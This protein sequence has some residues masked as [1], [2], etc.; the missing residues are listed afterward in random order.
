M[1]FNYVEQH[2]FANKRSELNE[3]SKS[4]ITSL[5]LNGGYFAINEGIFKNVHSLLFTFANGKVLEVQFNKHSFDITTEEQLSDGNGFY[6]KLLAEHK[7]LSESEH[8]TVLELDKP[9]QLHEVYLY[10]DDVFSDDDS[11]LAICPKALCLLGDDFECVVLRDDGSALF[12]LAFNTGDSRLF[13][14]YLPDGDAVTLFESS[15][16][17]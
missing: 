11:Y 10:S 3:L 9:L 6:I 4:D 12:A 17:I 1:H 7:T 5:L 14:Q 16:V 13:A 2:I 15:A 8:F